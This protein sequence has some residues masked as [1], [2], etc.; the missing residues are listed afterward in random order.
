MNHSNRMERRYMGVPPRGDVMLEIIGVCPDST[1]RAG[2]ARKQEKKKKLQDHQGISVFLLAITAMEPWKNEQGR[3][4][5]GK[6]DDM[7]VTRQ[8][9]AIIY[10]GCWLSHGQR[11]IYI[12]QAWKKYFNL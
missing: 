6:S 8:P 3:R 1:T 9:R 7:P 5:S 11:H 2:G 4:A 10:A 12:Y